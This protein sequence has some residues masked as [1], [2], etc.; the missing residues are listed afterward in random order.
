MCDFV[1][2]KLWLVTCPGHIQALGVTTCKTPGN[3]IAF[4]WKEPVTFGAV[5]R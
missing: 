2:V 3:Q 1:I 5:C 4:P